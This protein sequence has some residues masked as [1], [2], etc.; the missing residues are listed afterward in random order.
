MIVAQFAH[1]GRQAQLLHGR[2][3]RRDGAKCGADAGLLAEDV[4]AKS[5]AFARHVRKIDVVAL[6][7]MLE[8]IRSQHLGDV[9]F[10]FCFA[11]FAKL[12]GHEVAVHPQHRRD[13]DGQVQIRTALSHTQFKECVDSCH[14]A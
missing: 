5:A 3:L 12:D 4:N 10:E 13:P 11:Q 6:A 2:H 1:D 14:N 9:G 8:L 7:Q